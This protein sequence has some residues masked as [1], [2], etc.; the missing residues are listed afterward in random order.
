MW[1]AQV[2]EAAD[3]DAETN[4]NIKSPSDIRMKLSHFLKTIQNNKI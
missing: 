4:W 1:E 2:I 3:A